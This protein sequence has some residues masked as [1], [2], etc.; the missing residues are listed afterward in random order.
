M[1]D[2]ITVV[3]DEYSEQILF[4]QYY[5]AEKLHHHPEMGRCG[6]NILLRFLNDRF[7]VFDFVTG[8]IVVEGK[9]SPQCDILVCKKSRI[10][11]IMEGGL[12]LVEP[13][14]CLL[15]IEVKGNVTTSD[16]EETIRKNDFFKWNEST[17]HIKLA[18]FSF[19]T[20]IGKTRL[21]KEFGY[22]YD[23]RIKAYKSKELDIEIPLDYFICLHRE[24]INNTNRDKQLF[25]LKDGEKPRKYICNSELPI[26]RNFINLVQ[27]LQV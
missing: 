18:I 17:T 2:E 8:F 15:V 19:K 27:S 20:R 11:R 3:Y 14:D 6:E 5:I 23:R 4:C 24:S 10:R 12:H 13:Q 1:E 7:S 26:T 25:F 22:C 9:Q 21:Y 16:L